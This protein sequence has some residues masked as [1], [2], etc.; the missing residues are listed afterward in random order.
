MA[1]VDMLDM[2][3]PIRLML[4][5]R[6]RIVENDGYRLLIAALEKLFFQYW[7]KNGCHQLKFSAYQRAHELGIDLPE[8]AP[9]FA[10][11]G[12]TEWDPVNL[13]P[14][15]SYDTKN[16]NL[17][18]CVLVTDMSCTDEINVALALHYGTPPVDVVPIRISDRYDGYGWVKKIPRVTSI[19]VTP[20][21]STLLENCVW[22]GSLTCLD[23]ISASIEISDGRKWSFQVPVAAEKSS[24]S[25]WHEGA[26]VTPD[27]E[28][29]VRTET[30]L[31]L[32]GG[33]SDEGDTYDTQ[34]GNFEQEL[35]EFFAKLCG[36]GECL[37]RD[38][39]EVL[40]KYNHRK[41][42]GEWSTARITKHGVLVLKYRNGVCKTIR[43]PASK[44]KRKKSGKAT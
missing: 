40:E 43:P 25:D 35:S 15:R 22:F 9:V 33:V 3:T 14:L 19:E 16:I 4:P 12:G 2:P 20:G 11:I 32:L 41:V 13:V 34:I 5:A 27:A 36:D 30:L 1:R 42:V 44:K 38:L 28:Q 6:T 21:K 17:A 23:S 24:E 7:L 29:A 31:C 37:R 18:K 26:W 39:L 8:S 10:P